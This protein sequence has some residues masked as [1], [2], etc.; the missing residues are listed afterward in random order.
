WY[1][2]FRALRFG[3]GAA[4]AI[5]ILLT[6]AVLVVPYLIYTFRTEAEQ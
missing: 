1:T 5:I 2:A 6:V 3:Q 4:I